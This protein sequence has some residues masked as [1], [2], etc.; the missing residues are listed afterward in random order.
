MDRAERW[1]S[2]AFARAG[3][4]IGGARG[5]DLRVHDGRL[6]RRVLA[7]GMMGLGDAYVDGWWDSPH[8]DQVFDRALRAGLPDALAKH[9]LVRLE[10]L[11]QRLFNRQ[12]R[13][14][15]RRH[16]ER[17]Y[18]LG[19]DLFE[20]MLDR[21]MTYS[22][23]YWRDA[24][25]LDDAQEAKL[26]LVCRKIGL[27]PGQRVLDIGCGWGSFASY[28]AE[29]HRAHVV[30]V[31]LAAEQV[32]AARERCHGLPVEFR[33]QDY[34]EVSD[35]FDH[36]VSIGMF[37]HV[38]H[39]NHRAFMRAAR[40][41]LKPGGLL[42]LHT[43]GTVRSHPDPRDSEVMW[44]ERRIF[45]G[46]SVPSMAQIGRALDDLFVAEDVQNFGADY[47]PTLMAWHENFERD[48]GEGGRLRE[49]YDERFHRTWR[50]YLL[51]CAGAFRSRKYQVWQFVLSPTGVR[52]GWRARDAEGAG[53]AA[54]PLPPVTVVT[55]RVKP[56]A[57]ATP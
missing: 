53:E 5:R 1:V 31:T 15:A 30:G 26:E 19:H 24:A 38:G 44:I 22:C 11:R 41:C 51:S 2:A 48:W 54:P 21:R 47:D 46:M 16:V 25:T 42:L 32:I 34:R 23:G 43:F 7:R 8:L 57:G 4:E 3:V 29:R 28:A 45:P 36:V 10:C 27:R 17:H 20:A 12:R 56:P 18:H 9:P 40:R 6:F 13:P 33:L 39:K 49:R 35:T 50:Y 14:A 55:D 52:A 37:E